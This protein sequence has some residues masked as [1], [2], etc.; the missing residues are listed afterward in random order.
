M[1][2]SRRNR[3]SRSRQKISPFDVSWFEE[4]V[5]SDDLDGLRLVRDRAPAGMDIAAGEYGWTAH[6]FRRMLEA[7]AV[8]VL[9]IDAT[10]AGGITG[11]IEAAHLA[12]AFGIAVSSHCAPA[13]HLHAAL[14]APRFAHLEWFADHVRVE[15][16]LF[17]GTTEP[18]LGA[19]T[20]NLARPGLGITLAR[21]ARRFR[22]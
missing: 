9:Q 3:R 21:D 11:F 2:P 19:L 13:I 18:I 17:D 10:R 12:D 5:S 14:G 7:H 4:P 22:L 15:A 1:G 6:Y 16:M 20:P 8:D